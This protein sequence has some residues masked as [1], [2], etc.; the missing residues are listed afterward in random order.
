M[1]TGEAVCVRGNA[2]GTARELVERD[3]ALTALRNL[4]GTLSPRHGH[5]VLVS[6]PTATGRSALLRAFAEEAAAAGALVLA[7]AGSPAECRLPYGLVH[8]LL[9]GLRLMGGTAGPRPRGADGAAVD[10]AREVHRTVARLA[11]TEP[12]V[13]VIDDVHHGD[14]ASLDCLRYAVRRLERAPVMLVV[15]EPEQSVPGV[16]SVH[17]VL[18]P[19]RRFTRLRTA[20]L[21]EDGVRALAARRVGAA[22]AQRLAP[23]LSAVTGGSPLL[24]HALLDDVVCHPDFGGAGGTVAEA[25]S[26]GEA[27]TRFGD[28]VLTCVNRCGPGAAEVARVLALFDE[29]A[30]AELVGE[31]TR[32]TAESVGQAVAALRASGLVEGLRFRHPAARSAVLAS[33]PYDRHRDLRL[34]IAELLH[35]QGARPA[36]VAQHLLRCG[37]PSG[38]AWAAPVLEAAAEAAMADDDIE[39]AVRCLCRAQSLPDGDGARQTL[40]RIKKVQVEWCRDPEQSQRQLR[41]LVDR[42]DRADRAAVSDE[43][44]LMLVKQLVWHG[45]PDTAERLISRLRSGPED[46]ARTPAEAA[47]RRFTHLWAASVYPA[48]LRTVQQPP[49]GG[50]RDGAP[51]LGRMDRPLRAMGALHDVLKPGRHDAAVAAADQL[52]ET[53]YPARRN[54]EVF[55]VA[56]LALEALLYADRAERAGR[57]SERLLDSSGDSQGRTW[58]ALLSW[59]AAEAALRQGDLPAAAERAQEA[60]KLIPQAGWGVAVG[61]PLSCLVTAYTGMGDFP[62]A[63]EHLARPVPDAMFRSRYGLHYLYARGGHALATGRPDAALTDFR[64]CGDLMREWGI[65]APGL[66]PWR[67]GAARAW[68]DKGRPERARRLVN[69]QMTRLGTDGSRARGAALRLLAATSPVRQRRTM[70]QEAAEVLQ[71]C[72]DRLE[73]AYALADLSR[74]ESELREHRRAWVLARKALQSARACGAGPLAEALLPGVRPKDAVPVADHPGVGALTPGERRVASLAADGYTNR[75]IAQRLYI[76]GSTVEQHLTKVYR[77]LSIRTRDELPTEF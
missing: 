68:L 56:V 46:G 12:V 67:L 62:A 40:V 15:A 76:T 59:A 21:S 69:D 65:D 53:V 17:S 73:A 20:P 14:R 41:D 54:Q 58:L 35:H 39:L 50:G 70:L 2:E 66:F 3:F 71:A 60:L 7:A 25:V 64:F 10:A 30:A 19:H 74:A 6:G 23:R 31:V 22:E 77:K 28:A 34:R 48:L 63:A 13:L 55:R 42:V 49:A 11:R 44:L 37:Q 52:L 1:L 9:P 75:E 18:L 57:W 72:G 38:A 4:F 45:S 47:E 24:V 33:L 5:A 29:P 27:G 61:L 8:Q 36:E 32:M 43:A 51:L 16:P 26:G